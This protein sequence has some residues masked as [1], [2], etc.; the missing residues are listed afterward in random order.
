MTIKFQKNTIYRSSTYLP[1]LI[2]Q[3][4][5]QC[6]QCGVTHWNNKPIALEVHHKDGNRTN[7]EKEN[8]ILLCPNCHAQTD[9]YNKSNKKSNVTDEELAE[10]IK[11]SA[12]IHQALMSVGLSTTGVQYARAN[13]VMEEYNIANPRQEA[14]VWHCEKCNTIVSAGSRL[15]LNCYAIA[16]QTVQRPSREEFKQEIRTTSFVALGRKYGVS[17]NAI[18]KWCVRYELPKTKKEI[19]Q[20]TDEEWALL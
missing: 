1:A 5:H 9:N 20:Y 4:G 3:R 15:C 12:S 14:K 19:L 8:L 7:N 6:E 16:Q 10:A 13:R 18:R 2:E 11:N 17:D